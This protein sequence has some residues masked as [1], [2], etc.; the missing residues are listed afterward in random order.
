ML[1]TTGAGLSGAGVAGRRRRLLCSDSDAER[2]EKKQGGRTEGQS[3]NK[4]QNTIKRA[5]AKKGK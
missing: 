1:R 5:Q 3:S 2:A 4:E